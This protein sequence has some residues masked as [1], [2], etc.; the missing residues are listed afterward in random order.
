MEFIMPKKFILNAKYLDDHISDVSWLNASGNPVQF[1]NLIKNLLEEA[2]LNIGGDKCDVISF[3]VNV[4]VRPY[5]FG[6]CVEIS[7]NGF[8]VGHA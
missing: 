4:E 1:E 7:V 8:K 2:K 3:P 5:I 6:V